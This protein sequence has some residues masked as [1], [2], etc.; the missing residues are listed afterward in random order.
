M[1]NRNGWSSFPTLQTYLDFVEQ[2][3]EVVKYSMVHAEKY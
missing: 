1:N 2:V 3:F